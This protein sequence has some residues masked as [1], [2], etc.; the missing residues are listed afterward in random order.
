MTAYRLFGAETSPYSLKVRSYLRY[1][2]IGFEWIPRS[3]ATEEEFRAHASAPT[4][5]LLI[6][7]NR[8]ASQDS[9][10]MLLALQTDHKEPESVPDDPA[11]EALALILEDY[12]DEWLNKA[13]F[14]CRWGDMPDKRHAA[15]RVLNQ[16]FAGKT[17]RDRKKAENQIMDSMAARLPLVGAD[18]GNAG[19]LKESFHRFAKLLDAHL[20]E[21]LFL[22]GGKPSIADFALAGQLQQLL[23]DPTPGEWLRERAPFVT[24]WCEFM[25]DPK[26]GAPFKSLP[27]LESTLLPIFQDEVSRTFLPW[28]AAN[29]ASAS[30]RKKAFSVTLDDGMFEQ[31]TQR[32]AAKSFKEMKKKVARLAKKADTLQSFLDTA[33]A[34]V[35]LD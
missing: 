23:M 20:Q 1:K 8:P 27:E 14:R 11:C 33:G 6:F 16:L 15:G 10:A 13:M 2:D 32:Y 35:I 17:P 19:T 34:K 12:A 5:P 31:S 9:T 7:P 29:A 4:V 25:E 30:R 26:A 18:E 21:H 28:A 24:A 22:F 3:A